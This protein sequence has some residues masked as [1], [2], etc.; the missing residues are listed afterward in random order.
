M[1]WF[2]RKAAIETKSDESSLFRFSDWQALID[3]SAQTAAGIMVSPLKALECPTVAAAMRIRVETLGSCGLFLYRRGADDERSRADDHPMYRLLHDRPNPWTSSSALVMQLETD[4]I[5]EGAGYAYA[6]RIGGRIIELIRLD[7]R[8]VV[9]KQDSVT[10]EPL[11][12]Y[13]S[14]VG[15]V[16]RYR[17]DEILHIQ[18]SIQFGNHPSAPR[19]SAIRQGRQ[20]IGLAM[21][22]EAHAA[23]LLANG[24]RPSGA[25]STGGKK[26][27]DVAF[28]RLKSSWKAGHSG[29]NAGGTAILEDGVTFTP[30]TFSSVDLEFNS[31]RIFQTVDIGR[32]LGVPPSMIFEMGRATWANSE[33]MAQAFLTFTLLGRCKLWQGAISRLLTAEEQATLYPEF[34]VDSLVKADLAARYAAFTAACGGPF[35]T[36]NEVRA[37]DNRPGIEGGDKL[38]PPANATGVSAT[39]PAPR[40][41]LE[42]VA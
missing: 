15:G 8:K 24:A 42:A 28:E 19:L 34:E 29:S 17:W 4:V 11:Y 12:E 5:A 7:P 20:A 30:I 16:T 9:E 40:P 36:A 38:R 3:Q 35:L 2:S 18:G 21:A 33:E 10:M 26:L 6:N 25:L 39:P 31:M 1:G 32:C 41:R 23:R 13:T 22:L 37:T 14:A 27:D